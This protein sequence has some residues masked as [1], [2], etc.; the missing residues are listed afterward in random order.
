MAPENVAATA[1]ELA[2][3]EK[4]VLWSLT[5]HQRHLWQYAQVRKKGFDIHTHTHT[6]TRMP[7]PHFLN[8]KL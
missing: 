6:H 7:F 3:S 8:S 1:E 4:E 5:G 2:K